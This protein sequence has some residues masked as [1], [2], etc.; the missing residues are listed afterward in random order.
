MQVTA[1]TGTAISRRVSRLHSAKGAASRC[2]MVE[3][4]RRSPSVAAKDS[5]K[6]SEKT[7]NGLHSRSS[8]SAAISEIMALVSRRK[9]NPAA[10]IR[11]MTAARITE[12]VAPATGT[13]SRISGSER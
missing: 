12:G 8:A 10:A 2:C 11:Y 4:N 3:A 6:L 13:N 9:M 1:P 5:C 7:A